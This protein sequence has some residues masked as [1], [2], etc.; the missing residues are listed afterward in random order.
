[1]N[2][3][4]CITRY[5]DHEHPKTRCHACGLPFVPG[6][7]YETTTRAFGGRMLII[8][9]HVVCA[10]AILPGVPQPCGLLDS[11]YLLNY[12]DTDEDTTEEWQSWYRLRSSWS[13]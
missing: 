8:D 7:Q 9:E 11:R 10:T 13:E 4:R 2:I 5:A 12:Y 3:V 1:M 6:D